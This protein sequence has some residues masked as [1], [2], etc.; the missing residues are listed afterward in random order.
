M[1]PALRVY[2]RR[3][4]VVEDTQE[5]SSTESFSEDQ[6]E[7]EATPL[8]RR[9][10]P[11]SLRN[12]GDRLALRE[13]RPWLA[14]S[15]HEAAG[16]YK[17]YCNLCSVELRL[18]KFTITRHA[19]T[20]RHVKAVNLSN[21]SLKMTSFI[22]T[23]SPA[24]QSLSI[25]LESA[26]ISG[27]NPTQLDKFL[28]AET[29]SAI[30]A[31]Q[32]PPS[33]GLINNTLKAVRKSQ[34][35]T[36]VSELELDKLPFSIQI[37][38]TKDHN[39]ESVVNTLISNI[40]GCWL[41]DSSVLED[42]TSLTI[43][44]HIRSLLND[45]GLSSDHLVSIPTD[46]CAAALAGAR[47]V[48]LRSPMA[49]G[50]R[51]FSHG[52]NLVL[53]HFSK[54][55]KHCMTMIRGISSY[56]HGGGH[57]SGRRARAVKMGIKVASLRYAPTRW[58]SHVSVGLSI[59]QQWKD[60]EVYLRGEQEL[61][62][63]AKQPARK[64]ATLMKN[65]STKIQLVLVT[66]LKP[67]LKIIEGSQGRWRS[68]T[69]PHHLLTLLQFYKTWKTISYQSRGAEV[70]LQSS[71][72]NLQSFTFSSRE[73][74]LMGLAYIRCAGKALV[75]FEK[76]IEETTDLIELINVFHPPYLLRMTIKEGMLRQAFRNF[77]R[78][79]K[80]L[81]YND[82]EDEFLRYHSE[83]RVDPKLP[84]GNAYWGRG[85]PANSC[86]PDLAVLAQRILSIRPSVAATE[87]TFSLM[88]LINGTQ[89]RRLS[90]EARNAELYLRFNGPLS[91]LKGQRRT[92]TQ[93]V[94]QHLP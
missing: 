30:K 81:L 7:E 55:L 15:E 9:E 38:E 24:S 33:K 65:A 82:I 62:T 56:L 93:N 16:E 92:F 85:S 57:L 80:G 1:E 77:P 79:F 22:P 90:S 49:V 42:Q 91:A 76:V 12:L 36:I 54:D 26:L 4:A 40:E 31:I 48:C 27:I 73:K 37:D 3:S 75:E 68:S 6:A 52:I 58:A 32:T 66:S 10:R 44:Q 13:G 29:I 11:R 59:M 2:V 64:L 69:P 51:C 21:S 60:L 39:G 89:R 35:D 17:S 63:S 70:D 94:E 19:S 34:R 46:N 53:K 41:L 28:T 74:V 78:L 47:R 5:C 45:L 14:A 72:C 50:V 8:G 43:K 84:F 71:F 18:D 67:F 83:V 25:V 86:F 20:P 61:E 23:S 88:K 87:S